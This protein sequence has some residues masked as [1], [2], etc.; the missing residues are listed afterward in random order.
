MRN[1]MRPGGI[2]AR[3]G[4][5]WL[6]AVSL[7][8]VTVWTAGA[9]AGSITDLG[10]LGGSSYAT[11]INNS[12]QVA[13]NSS[14]TDGHTHAF[15][16]SEGNMT[17]LGTLGGYGSW[18]YGINDSGQVVGDSID[19][20][21]ITA[22]FLSSGSAMTDMR[23]LVNKNDPLYWDFTWYSDSEA[24]AINDNG[25]IA[26]IFA[27][28]HHAFLYSAGTLT[29]IGYFSPS[30][31]NDHGEI[32][33]KYVVYPKDHAVLYSGGTLTDL[34]ALG[35]LAGTVSYATDINNSGEIVG[36]YY[37]SDGMN[38]FLY[39]AGTIT[40]LGNLGKVGTKAMGIND[41]G[42]IVGYSTTASGDMHAFLYSDG[43]M[44][45]LGTWG[46]G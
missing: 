14:T 12:G 27:S 34:G 3:G 29:D 35:C 31:I 36:Y 5:G 8:I 11:G 44:T 20:K 40:D 17:D 23:D 4:L 46:N 9:S 7:V 25:Q 32:V 30:A 15:L 45:D 13:G 21:G 33:G 39:S 1:K 10:S 16:Y 37:P 41:S 26:G 2:R 42:E 28:Y 22:A 24:Y 19:A 18:A 43:A 6:L 38:A